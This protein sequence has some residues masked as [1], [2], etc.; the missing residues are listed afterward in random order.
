MAGFLHDVGKLVMLASFKDEMNTAIRLAQEKSL[1][2]Y[3][4]EKEILG[5]NHG[6]IGAHLLSL[7]GLHDSILEAITFHHNPQ[8]T[9]QPTKN[10]LTA[11]YIANM[12]DNC[13]PG[14]ISELLPALDSEYL[15]ALNL[16]DQLPHLQECC[17][18]E[19]VE[20]GITQ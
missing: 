15:K 14:D 5:A 13:R 4:A 12:I 16:V 11:V 19:I 2:P 6:E 7:W 18:S 9:A 3:I 20:E 10:I 17:K 1:Q 8:H